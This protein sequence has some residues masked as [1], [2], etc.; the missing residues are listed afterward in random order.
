MADIALSEDD[1]VAID[2]VLPAGAA[3]GERYAP[4]GVRA[5][6]V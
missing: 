4:E 2:M 5:L 3:I 6:N 1:L